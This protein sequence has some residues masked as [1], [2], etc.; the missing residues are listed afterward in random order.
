M[1][2]PYNV[3]NINQIDGYKY[4]L[5][6]N[7]WCMI[8]LSG[9]EPLLRIYAEGNTPEETMDILQNVRAFFAV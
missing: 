1:F 8:R 5:E 2:G 3:V 4:E 9:T 7:C 6:N